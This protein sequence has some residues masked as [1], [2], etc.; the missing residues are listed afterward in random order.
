MAGFNKG[1]D[2]AAGLYDWFAVA[3]VV[4]TGSEVTMVLTPIAA[5]THSTTPRMASIPSKLQ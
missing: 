3:T 4:G 1:F 2:A 5:I